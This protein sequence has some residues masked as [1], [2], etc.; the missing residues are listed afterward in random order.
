MNFDLLPSHLET[1]TSLPQGKQNYLTQIQIN[2]NITEFSSYIFEEKYIIFGFKFIIIC[3]MPRSILNR[4]SGRLRDLAAWNCIKMLRTA[5]N[6]N[7]NEGE[8][9]KGRKTYILCCYYRIFKIKWWNIPY[10]SSS[11][12]ILF[13]VNSIIIAALKILK[14]FVSKIIE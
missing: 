1:Q 7:Y 10:I 13:L 6:L 14:I 2:G 5:P 12:L 11:H 3:S 9:N 8:L 4:V